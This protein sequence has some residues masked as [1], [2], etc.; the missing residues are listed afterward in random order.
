MKK[1]FTLVELI[2][3]IIILGIISLI[4][5]PVVRNQVELVRNESYNRTV[6]SIVE[7]ARRYVSTGEL[8]Y[9]T[10]ERS[11]TLEVLIQAGLLERNDLINPK[12][13][14]PLGGC[15]YYK[16]NESNNIFEYRYEQNC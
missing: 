5:F 8:G 1:G 4:V 3:V 2:S 11:V 16:W 6:N 12:T 14:D 10:E 13:E 7:A 15:V 9:P